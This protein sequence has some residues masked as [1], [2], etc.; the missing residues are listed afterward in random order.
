MAV[1]QSDDV[2][3]VHGSFLD[4]DWSDG[5]VVFANSTCFDDELMGERLRCAQSARV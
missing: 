3:L 1:S 4:W 2:S 5:D